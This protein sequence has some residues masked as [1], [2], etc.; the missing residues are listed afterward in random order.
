MVYAWRASDLRL[1]PI[2]TVFLVAECLSSGMEGPVPSSNSLMQEK[3][4]E[5]Y[6]F[7]SAVSSFVDGKQ[8]LNSSTPPTEGNSSLSALVN[9]KVVLP[10]PPIA[11]TT[12]VLI[13]WKIM[14]R[15][16]APCSR[17]YRKDQ[18]LTTESNCTD[19]RATWASR[20]DQNPELQIDPVAT[21]HDGYYVCQAVTSDGNFQHVYHLQ[22]L[23]PPEV[24]LFLSENRTVVCKANAGKPAAQISWT[25]EGVCV[26]KEEYQGDGTVTVLS[27]CHWEGSNVSTVTCSVSHATGNKHLTLELLPGANTSANLNILFIILPLTTLFITGSIYFLK[28]NGFRKC[29]LKKQ[30]TASVIED[31]MQPYASYTEKNNP[32]YDTTN[33][34]EKERAKDICEDVSFFGTHYV[35]IDVLIPNA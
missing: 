32:L 22:V 24:T 17:A 26:L 7:D 3:V 35:S 18:N 13:T 16:K 8:M 27:A 21:T 20:P 19:E 34:R 5:N 10:C 9:T 15:D 30:E 4:K 28:I 23:V 2:L 12:L 14:V 31:E 29:K 33:K 11:Y 6:T 1:L 25:P